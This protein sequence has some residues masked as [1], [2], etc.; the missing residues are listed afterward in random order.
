MS[1]LAALTGTVLTGMISV[2][3]LVIAAGPPQAPA[4]TSDGAPTFT[5]DVAPIL[6]ANCVTCHRP[7]EI[8]PMSLIRYQE[9]RPG[10]RA[11][12]SQVH[13]GGMQRIGTHDGLL[14][15]P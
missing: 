2:S 10:A 14:L 12:S 11:I 8:A 7:G 13:D 5:R 6:Y 4:Q 3:A 15:V 9:A 1:T